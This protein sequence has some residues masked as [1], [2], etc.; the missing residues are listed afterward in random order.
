MSDRASPCPVKFK[1]CGKNIRIAQDV[2]VEHPEGFE[3]GEDV[4]IH[5]GTRIPGKP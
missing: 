4:T 1:A 5:A 3:L 2:D